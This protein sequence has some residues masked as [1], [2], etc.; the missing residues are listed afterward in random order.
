MA[1]AIE[2]KCTSDNR[3]G[4]SA[5]SQAALSADNDRRRGSVFRKS[6]FFG[7][8]NWLLADK[9]TRQAVA[10]EGKQGNRNRVDGRRE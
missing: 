5:H 9:P 4:V 2:W 7:D 6:R 8:W 3:R 1:T 10:G